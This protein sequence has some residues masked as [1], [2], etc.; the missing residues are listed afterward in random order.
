MNEDNAKPVTPSTNEPKLEDLPAEINLDDIDIDN[1]PDIAGDIVNYMRDGAHRVLE[2]GA[3][4]AMAIQILAMAASGLDGYDGSSLN[5]ITITLGLSAAGKER[6]Q[7]VAKS[8]LKPNDIILYGDIRSDKDL[9]R[10]LVDGAKCFYLKDEAHSILGQVADKDQNKSGIASMLLE[11][12]TSDDITLSAMHIGEFQDKV[13][14]R[15]SRLEKMKQAKEAVKMGFNVELE[16]DKIKHVDFEIEDFENKITE[17][18]A[19]YDKIGK[20]IEK[21]SLSLSGYS[22]PTELAG[23]I[24]ERTIGNGF[25]GRTVIVDCGD[26]RTHLNK[27]LINVSQDFKDKMDLR[28]KRLLAR[29][30]AIKQMADD[31]SKKSLEAE[32]NGE[33]YEITATKEAQ[34]LF[35]SISIHYDQ[36]IYIN[37]HRLGALYARLP[38]R[39]TSLASTLA[40]DNLINGSLVIESSHVL[41]ALKLTLSSINYLYSNLRVNEAVEGETTEDKLEGI[42]EAILK[43]LT[44]PKNDKKEGWRYKSELKNYLKRQK[45]YQ[46]ISKEL[47]PHNQDAMENAIALLKG[48]G[49][50]ITD[51]KRIKKV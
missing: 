9:I 51:E 44:V 5:L 37:H 49:K 12:S 38:N 33:S 13:L 35:A 16:Q 36:D 21:P 48:D 45:Y 31:T 46:E 34:S 4:S 14:T 43:R 18:K 1:P 15:I 20:G 8:L 32:F 3:Y 26:E 39:V 24:N 25:L 50:V 19:T 17:L 30:G 6:P 28:Y 7:R 23:I 29:V 41:F 47:Q 2:G 27:N 42:K 11:I 10:V 40:V 22:T